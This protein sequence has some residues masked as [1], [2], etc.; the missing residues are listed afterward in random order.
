MLKLLV[1]QRGYNNI[2]LIVNEITKDNKVK[3]WAGFSNSKKESTAILKENNKGKYFNV[4]QLGN[5]YLT[6]EQIEEIEGKPN[7]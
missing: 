2:Q 5:I 3:F 6:D 4:S 7:K 1:S